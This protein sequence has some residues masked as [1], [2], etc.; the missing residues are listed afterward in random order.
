MV[1]TVVLYSLL[2]LLLPSTG[3]CSNAGR[4]PLF[5]RISTTSLSDTLPTVLEERSFGGTYRSIE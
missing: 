4:S 2:L 3:I 5:R 1:Y